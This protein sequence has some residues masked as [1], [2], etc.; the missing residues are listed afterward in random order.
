[1]I[2][3]LPSDDAQM[4][5]PVLLA[6]TIPIL[7]ACGQHDA[8]PDSDQARVAS[9]APCSTPRRIATLPSEVK[10]ASGVAASRRHPGI[11]WLH[12]DSG[13][14]AVVY[15]ADTTGRIQ[16]R[17][18]VTGA[19]NRDWED[20][21][22]GTC[23]TGDC[24]YIADTGDNRLRHDHGVIYRIPEPAPGDTVSATAERFPFQ[25]PDG[26]RDVEAM[27]LLP[28]GGLYLISK[29]RKHPAELFRYPAPLRA[30]ETVTLELVQA[31]SDDALPIPYQITAAS[32]SPDGR[33]VAVRS[34]SAL[35]LYRPRPD[36][37]LAPA[38]PPPGLSLDPLAEP[39]GEGVEI[40]DDGTIFLASEAGLAR[41]PGTIGVTRCELQR[42]TR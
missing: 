28:D 19:T 31:L 20:I 2:P 16:A 12:N 32:A 39:Q 22:L 35:Q 33:W 34:Y 6:L 25:Y 18:R 23:P 11:L 21:A 4:R 27:Y 10:E 40:T 36:G 42:L 7:T 15:A 3:I 17:V 26:P 14:D 29:G 5:F 37:T 38:L 30:G 24:I 1:M 41:S 9:A 13:A 8:A